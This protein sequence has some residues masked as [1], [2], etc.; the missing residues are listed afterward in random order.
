MA[1]DTFLM[2]NDDDADR[3]KRR[4]DES[5]AARDRL[6]T[7]TKE[8]FLE[9]Q[10]NEIFAPVQDCLTRLDIVLRRF[11][12]SVEIDHTWE[13]FDEQRLRR[14][15]KVKSI[16]SDRQLS[17]DFNIH[18]ARIFHLDKCYQ[19]SREIETLVR[20]IVG[21]VEQFLKRDPCIKM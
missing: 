20:V 17:L 5:D 18:G 4:W 15:A 10:A 2:S 21:E 7:R 6:E 1:I 16:Q 12:V 9:E 8:L 3:V 14:T 13:R 11:N 19:F